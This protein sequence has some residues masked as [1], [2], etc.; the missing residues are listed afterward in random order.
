M[1]NRAR[2]FADSHFWYKYSQ[3][4]LIYVFAAAIIAVASMLDEDFL[5]VR[6]FS[7][8]LLTIFPIAMVGFAQTLVIIMGGIDLSLGSIVSLTNVV[9][10]AFMDI[11]N[12]YSWIT[13]VAVS[14]LTG[15]LCGAFNGL[16]ITKGRLSPVIATI[17]TMSIYSG[18]ALYISPIPGGKVGSVF[19]KTLTGRLGFPTPLVLITTILV[20]LFILSSK[21][22]FSKKLRAVGGN[23]N[24]AFVTGINVQKVKFVTYCAAGLLSGI[25]GVFLTAQMKT[26]DATVGTSFTMN[27]IAV[28]VIGGTL[29]TGAVGNVIG[30]LA[31]AFILV[32]INNILNLVGVSSF[33]QYVFQ[34]LILIVALAISSFRTRA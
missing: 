15:I 20:A 12:P 7:N 34:G 4:I 14:I 22:R 13:A 28:T 16:I 17:A 3:I 31:G 1:K 8:L 27:S 23:E 19:S 18:L 21:T 25:A 26:G 30:T 10:V 24:A 5:S 29:L 9:C 11:K 32:V 33:Y 2:N 6:N